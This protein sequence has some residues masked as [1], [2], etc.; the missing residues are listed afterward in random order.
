M[1]TLPG[2]IESDVCQATTEKVLKRGEDYLETMAVLSVA[3]R[4]TD[5]LGDVEGTDV[6]PYRVRV[7]FDRGG[8]ADAECTCPYEWE[9]WCKH[10][11][12]VL[13]TC[14]RRPEVVDV[15]PSLEELTAGLDREQLAGLLRLLAEGQP[16]LVD[17]IEEV[18]SQRW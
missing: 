14:L 8:V 9:G 5:G 15:R 18:I 1:F 6:E 13:L 16:C 2:L 11:V 3:Q 12:A 4:G 10:I 7:R 17:A